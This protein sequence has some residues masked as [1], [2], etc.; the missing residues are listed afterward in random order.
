MGISIIRDYQKMTKKQRIFFQYA[1]SKL[2]KDL[3][4][5]LPESEDQR[6]KNKYNKARD[7]VKRKK[8]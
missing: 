1:F 7:I 6:K 4:K 3:E 5:E 8:S 2:Q